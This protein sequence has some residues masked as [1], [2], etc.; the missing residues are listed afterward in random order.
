MRI[1]T[2]ILFFICP[3]L[4]FSQER[5][6]GDVT[7]AELRET[8]DPTFPNA[9]AVILYR[10]INFEYGRV[11]EVHERVKIYNSEAFKYS[12][13]TIPFDGMKALKAAT[14]NLENGKIDRTKVSRSGIFK[15]EVSEEIEISKLTFPKVKEGSIIELRYKVPFIGLSILYTQMPLPIRYQRIFIENDYYGNLSIRQNQYVK[16]P[17]QSYEKT[18]YRLF[19]GE[20]IPPLREESFVGNVDNFR[21]KILLERHG[22][23]YRQSWSNVARDYKSFDWFGDQLR[24]GYA[25]Y[26]KDLNTLLV[27]VKDTL[28]IAKKI[29][30]FVKDTIEWN[31]QYTR[32]TEYVKNVFRDKKGSSG[33]INIMLVQMLKSRGLDAN[34]ILVA[35]K[36]AGWVMYPHIDAF[37]TVLAT[38]KIDGKMYILDGSEEHT[39]FAQLPLHYIND[40]GLIIRE[41][42]SHELYWFKIEEPSKNTL[43][44]NATLHPEKLS[45]QGTVKKQITNYNALSF[46]DHYTDLRKETY[47]EYLNDIPLFT[48]TN[49]V[50]KNVENP[51]RPIAISY[52][53]ERK[54]FVE[55]IAGSLYFEPL[56]IWGLEENQFVEEDRLYPIDFEH[57][58]IENYIINYTIPDGY[59]VESLPEGKL[60]TMEKGIGSL[61]FNIQQRGS[62]LQVMFS[63][64]FNEYLIPADYYP[65][66]QGLYSEYLKISKSKIVLSKIK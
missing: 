41:D 28:E 7:E 26:K 37:N 46:R 10:D 51:D 11:L 59:K 64:E 3:V 56:L 50:K 9:P 17:I 1:L 36:S 29:D 55:N 43:I 24:T 63:L 34:P 32:G 45:V 33:G 38:V 53:F 13:W 39:K 15:E 21:G 23:L 14:Y 25:L 44:V 16:L 60:V 6:F 27:Q 35:T 49:V 62:Q 4:V 18:A 42:G 47:E 48:A 31:K 54:D 57:P 52:D 12:D 2:V 19:V 5:K 20:N 40:K 58:S 30:R 65:A 8:A 22:V 66:I 61:T